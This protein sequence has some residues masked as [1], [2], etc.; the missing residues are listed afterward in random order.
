M[1]SSVFVV[2][3]EVAPVSHV[4]TMDDMVLFEPEDEKN[5]HTDDAVARAAG[6]PAAIAAGVQFMSYVLEM[7]QQSYG[8]SS[9]TGTVLDLRI[10]AP[11]FAGDTVTARGQVS[12]VADGRAVLDVW[13]EN[14]R[15]EQVIAGTAEVPAGAAP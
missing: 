15:G 14:Q 3:S 4:V 13:C 1:A 9:V 11:V 6:L 2:G 12:G 8:A 10:R 7:L 5:I